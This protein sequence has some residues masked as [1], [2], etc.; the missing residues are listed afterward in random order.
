MADEHAAADR[1]DHAIA[2]A[3]QRLAQA[4]RRRRLGPLTASGAAKTGRPA[5]PAA[6]AP[7]T[8]QLVAATLLLGVCALPLMAALDPQVGGFILGVL[9]LRV[10]AIRWPGLQPGMLVLALLT[11]VGGLNV[12]DAYRGVAGQEPGT[13]L[14]LSMVAL[15]LLEVRSKRDLRVL[16]LVLGFV[17]VVQFLFDESLWRAL[18]MVALAVASFALLRD[19]GLPTHSPSL[20]RR[21]REGLGSTGVMAVQAL[22][23][24]LVLFLLFPR[25]DTPL[26]DLGLDNPHAITGLK[27]WLEP[28]SITD[29]VVSGEPVMR[30]RFDREPALSPEAMYWRGPVLWHA[31]GNRFE[32]AAPGDFPAADVSVEALSEPVTYTALLEPS[33]QRWIT[34]LDMPISAPRG[35]ALTSDLQLL[36]DRAIDERELYRLRSAVEYR[37]DGLTLDEELAATAL[38]ANKVTP[39]MRELVARWIADDPPPATVVQRAL[40]HFNRQPFRYSLLAP[41]MGEKAMDGFLFEEQVGFCEHY[42]AAF[43]LLMR[44]ADI[45]T[46]IVLGYLGGERNPYSGDYLVRQSEAHAWTEVWLPEQGWTRVD[47]TAAVAAERV[48][49]DGG[50]AA[51][52]ANAPARFR[53]DDGSLVGRA[54]RNLHLA[55]D[56]FDAAWQ[57][58][59]VGFSRFKQQRLLSGLGL[60]RFRDFGLVALMAL[61]G[62]GVMLAWALWL[63]RPTPERDPVAAAY[64]EFQRRLRRIDPVLAKHPDEG[65]LDHHARLVA[66]RPD[67]AGDAD[68]V[69]DAYVRLRYAGG[70]A[71]DD[72]LGRLQRAIRDLRVRR[73]PGPPAPSRLGRR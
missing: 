48:D 10:I 67:L 42:A 34:A 56:A 60:G 8:A 51:L 33:D 15:K 53:V 17:L 63:A 24:T 18:L 69:V 2:W 32:P 19:L 61:A 45:P 47:P 62:A 72:T 1:F 39:R 49:P 58:W 41:N 13:A 20:P 64:K 40:D 65:P 22:P 43:T 46:R 23:L 16:L 28:G 4:M 57:S 54:I 38:P 73:R 29:L 59:V 14:L 66:A 36:A 44:I 37:A 27:D 52:G 70:E 30:V 5:A 31:E 7:D 55:A 25:L 26:W 35:A 71:G 50:I 11:L 3:R 21:I 6:E 9:A 12:L 68:A